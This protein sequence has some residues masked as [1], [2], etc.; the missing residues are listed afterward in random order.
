MHSY[1]VSGK[2]AHGDEWLDGRRHGR[3]GRVQV[4][5]A[6]QRQDSTC[7][8]LSELFEGGSDVWHQR[9]RNLELPDASEMAQEFQPFRRVRL[10]RVAQGEQHRR[11]V[12]VERLHAG[13]KPGELPAYV[14]QDGHLPIHI[15]T[16]DLQPDGPRRGRRWC[17]SEIVS[18]GDIVFGK[19]EGGVVRGPQ[20]SRTIYKLGKLWGVERV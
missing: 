15:V 14:D 6:Q 13:E 10:S 8:I 20:R 17:E 9:A 19:S 11:P 5:I 18:D 3:L 2:P 16:R 7:H 1:G 12:R 4:E